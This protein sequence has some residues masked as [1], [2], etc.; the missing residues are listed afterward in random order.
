M[1][2]QEQICGMEPGTQIIFLE[3]GKRRTGHLEKNASPAYHKTR[4]ITEPYKQ[5][6]WQYQRF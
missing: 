6:L 3:L 2:F 5:K 1:S 4:K